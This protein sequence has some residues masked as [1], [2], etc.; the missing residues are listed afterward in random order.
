MRKLLYVLLVLLFV[1]CSDDVTLSKAEYNKLKGVSS[2]YPKSFKFNDDR[3]SKY[4]NWIIVLGQD[5]HEY[6]TNNVYLD[7]TVLIHY[8]DCKKCL[9]K[10]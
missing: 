6:L 2:E 3:I 9:S 7:N 4:A 5:S 8:P 10:K 1:S